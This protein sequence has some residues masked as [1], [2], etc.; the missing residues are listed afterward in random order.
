MSSYKV[1]E[2]SINI[3]GGVLVLDPLQAEARRHR[4]TKLGGNRYVVTYPPV[5]FK[6]G[7]VFELEGELPKELVHRTQTEGFSKVEPVADK[8]EPGKAKK[9]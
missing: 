1:T 4:L 5:T 2:A 3:H 7:E 9:K 6:R 8:G